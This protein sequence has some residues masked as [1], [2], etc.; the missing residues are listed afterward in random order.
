MNKES[1]DIVKLVENNPIAKLNNVSNFDNTKVIKKLAEIFTTEEQ[2]FYMGNFYMYLNYNPDK[3]FVIDLDNVWKWLGYSTIG[4]CKTVIIKNFGE[5]EDYKIE[6][7]ASE[8]SK[9]IKKSDGTSNNAIENKKEDEDEDDKVCEEKKDIK[10]KKGGQNKERI[11]LTVNCFKDLCM[12]AGTDKSKEVRKYYRLLEGVINELANEESKEF[13]MLLQLKNEENEKEKYKL[14]EETIVKQFPKNEQCIYICLIDNKSTKG[15]DEIKFGQSNYLE[16]RLKIHKKTFENCRLIRAFKVKNKIKIENLIKKHPIL[17]KYIR[18]NII[19]D[20]NYTELI[21]YKELTLEKIFTLIEEIIVENEYNIENYD[22]LLDQNE[23]LEIENAKLTKSIKEVEAKNKRLTE[24]LAKYGPNHIAEAGATEES[25]IIQKGTSYIKA[26][27]YLYAFECM[28]YRYKVGICRINV[29][30]SREK[31]YQVAYPNGSMKYKIPV[32]NPF[33]EKILQYLVKQNCQVI[34]KETYE[35]SFDEIQLIIDMTAKLEK[36]I[37]L[38]IKNLPKLI[39]NIDTLLEND[40]IEKLNNESYNNPEEVSIKKSIRPV[41][42]INKE[43]GEIIKSYKSFEEAGKDFGVTGSAIGTALREK[44]PCQDQLF[45]YAGISREE[46]YADQPVTKVNCN[47]HEIV[48]FETIAAA[49][50]DAKIS[51]PAM[52]VRINTNVHINNWHWIWS[53]DA[54][55]YKNINNVTSSII[56]STTN[57]QTNEERN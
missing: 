19:D 51:P 43:T 47:T 10:R 14:L 32:L 5:N 2:R 40:K 4:N 29:F 23:A 46:Q 56:T 34:D 53:P 31:L 28:K 45:R 27:Q 48:N 49:A 35:C 55:H 24:K 38:D 41:D 44:K 52:R 11:L 13:A 37:M 7:I 57:G 21:A 25:R 8:S 42:L 54:T 16:E 50:V 33:V 26:S 36:L 18:S 6:K 1:F 17:S 39:E 9:A 3:D 12:V 15:E 22:K 20:K 30:E